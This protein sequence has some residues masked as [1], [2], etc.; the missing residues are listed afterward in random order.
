MKNLEAGGLGGTAPGRGQPLLQLT[1]VKGA[2]V[3]GSRAPENTDL[4]ARVTG[5]PSSG[6]VIQGNDLSQAAHIVETTG[7]ASEDAV[8]TE[9][10]YTGE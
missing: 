2:F 8:S 7:G 4:Y 5:S 1:G 9:G 3:H 10:N 6:I